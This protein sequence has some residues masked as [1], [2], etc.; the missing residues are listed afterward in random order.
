MAAEVKEVGAILGVELTLYQARHSGPSI[1]RARKERDM[2]EVKKQGGWKA[3]K[4]LQRYEKSA[5]LANTFAK[6]TVHQKF[7]FQTCE[8]RLADFMSGLAME[9]PLPVV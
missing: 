5:R 3:W 6:M 4:S 7:F 1:D 8:R 2:A 9:I